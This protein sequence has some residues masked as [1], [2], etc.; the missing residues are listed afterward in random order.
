MIII[1]NIIFKNLIQTYNLN[2]KIF[3]I[4]RFNNIKVNKKD[5]VK[6]IYSSSSNNNYKPLVES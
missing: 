2:I 5:K 3:N 6:M 1:N 4:N